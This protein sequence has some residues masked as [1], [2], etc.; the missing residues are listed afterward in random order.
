MESACCPRCGGI[1]GIRG[2][3]PSMHPSAFTPP[4]PAERAEL[5]GAPEHEAHS[6]LRQ[7]GTVGLGKDAEGQGQPGQRE[8][9]PPS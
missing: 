5:R 1:W 2:R 3:R 4:P 8:G 9:G 6:L 7:T